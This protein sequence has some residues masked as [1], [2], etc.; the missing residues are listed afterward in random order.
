MK[1]IEQVPPM[2]LS[3]Q[4]GWDAFKANNTDSYGGGVV[5]FAERWARLMQIELAQGMTLEECAKYT[6]DEA[7]TEGITGFMYGCAVSALSRAWKHGESLRRWHNLDTQIS[8]EGERANKSGAV[9]NPAL[10]NI[11]KT[12][13]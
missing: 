10:L 1:R 12:G 13:Q 11:Q 4:Q 5:S 7:D 8:N 2:E 9:L 6:S 3:D